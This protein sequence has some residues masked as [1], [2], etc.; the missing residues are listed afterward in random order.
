MRRPVVASAEFF[1]FFHFSFFFFLFS[2]TSFGFNM[3]ILGLSADT[4]TV[5]VCTNALAGQHF[6]PPKPI[7]HQLGDGLDAV[8]PLALPVRGGD[9]GAEA[10][11]QHVVFVVGQLKVVALHDKRALAV[12]G[13]G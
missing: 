2:F 4:N 10:R 5:G 8:V 6:A 11:V 3:I 13:H 7:A 9:L 12:L 1:I